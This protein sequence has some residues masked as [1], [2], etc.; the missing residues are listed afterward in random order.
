LPFRPVNGG[1]SAEIVAFRLFLA[2]QIVGIVP[3]PAGIVS[4]YA[5]GMSF[6]TGN[7]KT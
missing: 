2:K 4:R 6:A 1:L 7:S 3:L 5:S